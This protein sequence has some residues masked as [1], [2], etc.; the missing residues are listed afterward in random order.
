MP[1]DGIAVMNIILETSITI[2]YMDITTVIHIAIYEVIILIKVKPKD[3]L[4]RGK[5]NC[6]LTA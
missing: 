5:K 6:N 2:D 3:Y 1:I 4:I